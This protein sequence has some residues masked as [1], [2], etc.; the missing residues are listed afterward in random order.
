[1]EQKTLQ[2]RGQTGD[3]RNPDK[4]A[5]LSSFS[6][7]HALGQ[8]DRHGNHTG[9]ATAVGQKVLGQSRRNRECARSANEHE[10]A[11]MQMFAEWAE[12]TTIRRHIIRWLSIYYSSA[13]FLKRAE[14]EYKLEMIVHIMSSYF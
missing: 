3:P 10:A 13:F 7:T 8:V 14:N 12:S 5:E 4:E 11:E 6:P 1:L 2:K 9:G